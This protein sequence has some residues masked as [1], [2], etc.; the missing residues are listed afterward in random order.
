MVIERSIG[1]KIR[2]LRRKR[3]MTQEMLADHLL[4]NKATISMYE[5]DQIDI[6]SSVLIEMADVLKVRPGYFIDAE[7]K[8]RKDAAMVVSDIRDI[9]NDYFLPAS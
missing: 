5:N 4:V 9:V 7:C 6:K 1:E 8:N 2:S 3:G